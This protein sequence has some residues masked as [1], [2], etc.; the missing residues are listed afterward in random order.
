VVVLGTHQRE[1]PRTNDEKLLFMVYKIMT[2]ISSCDESRGVEKMVWIC[3]LSG[4]NMRYNGSIAFALSLLHTLQDHF[5][6]RLGRVF[7]LDSPW[8]FRTAYKAL[9]PFLNEVTKQKFVFS[10]DKSVLFE[11]I[12]RSQVEQRFGGDMPYT[13]HHESY[14]TALREHEQHLR[15][16]G[17]FR[18][19]RPPMVADI[20]VPHPLP[21]ARTESSV[22]ETDADVAAE[23]ERLRAGAAS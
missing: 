18:Q 3:D 5:P 21:P 2:A 13:Y 11:T 6:E 15:R 8:V 19:F 7:F 14:L 1:I 22:S 20:P 10:D 9:V 4:Y 23:L 17:P 12:D 16:G